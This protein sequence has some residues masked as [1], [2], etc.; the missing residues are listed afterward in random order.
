MVLGYEAWKAWRTFN[1]DI[2]LIIVKWRKGRNLTFVKFPSIQTWRS[3]S[4]L[5]SKNPYPQIFKT[6]YPEITDFAIETQILNVRRNPVPTP[7]CADLNRSS[8][9][10]TPSWPIRVMLSLSW[11]NFYQTCLLGFLYPQVSEIYCSE[12]VVILDLFCLMGD[13]GGRVSSNSYCS[14]VVVNYS[15]L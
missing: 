12:E 7:A 3:L 2:F 1:W 9:K 10:N 8:L 13:G 14:S 4:S 5:V 11:Y 15:L 6:I